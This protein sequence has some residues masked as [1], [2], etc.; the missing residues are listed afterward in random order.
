[1]G[2]SHAL[3][4]VEPLSLSRAPCAALVL[5]SGRGLIASPP[6]WSK[7]S[8]GSAE[9][10]WKAL[11]ISCTAAQQERAVSWRDL[12]GYISITLKGH[13][14]EQQET[15]H[16]PAPADCLPVESLLGPAW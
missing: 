3:R 4:A 11:P 9:A 13:H 6:K 15:R 14:L 8:L 12:S 7:D 10:L 16:T 2:G 5:L 1:M